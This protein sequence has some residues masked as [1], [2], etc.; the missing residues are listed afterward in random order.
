VF[1][2]VRTRRDAVRERRQIADAAASGDVIAV[3]AVGMNPSRVTWA[4]AVD[5]TTFEYD[6][7]RAYKRDVG[8]RRVPF[9]TARCCGGA[10][11]IG[12]RRKA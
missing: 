1:R 8:S 2:A 9:R 10:P 3:A 11:K 5:L 7:L 12:T 4:G 6:D